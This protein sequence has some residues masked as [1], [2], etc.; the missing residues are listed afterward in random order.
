MHGGILKRV[1]RALN[2]RGHHTIAYRYTS[3]ENIYYYLYFSCL[4]HK[5]KQ[6]GNLW[7]KSGFLFS[8]QGP[9]GS[10]GNQQTKKF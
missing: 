5:R 3:G 1:F 10:S 6:F 8:H 9:L 2:V 7:L 4:T